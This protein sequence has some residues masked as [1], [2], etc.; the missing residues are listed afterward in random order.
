MN[1]VTEIVWKDIEQNE[2]LKSITGGLD[3]NYSIINCSACFY[4]F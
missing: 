4:A 1:S 3:F 2:E